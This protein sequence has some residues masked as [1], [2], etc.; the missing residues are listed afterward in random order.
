MDPAA[1]VAG[2]HVPVVVVLPTTYLQARVPADVSSTVKPNTG[3]FAPAPS[4]A[5]S[6][7]PVVKTT[8]GAWV[9]T[10]NVRD[11]GVAA[12]FA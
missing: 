11:F 4:T 3:E 9:S 8:V 6:A 2:E 7:G 10:V 5:L 12:L 1:K